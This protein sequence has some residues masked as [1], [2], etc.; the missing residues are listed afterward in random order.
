L[1]AVEYATPIIRLYDNFIVALQGGMSD[2]SVD[3]LRADVTER[4]GNQTARGLILDVSAL[5]YMDS[6]VTRA[7]R[8]LA[9]IA[10]LMGVTTVVCGLSP[11]I[12][13]TLIDMGLELPG[14]MT[15]LNMERALEALFR[16]REQ[17]ANELRSS[18]AV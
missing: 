2:A 5:A 4:I 1:I 6:F 13:I 10:R 17:D 11:E 15:A 3:R 16:A 18:D 12:A 14:V 8:D 9:V 7:V